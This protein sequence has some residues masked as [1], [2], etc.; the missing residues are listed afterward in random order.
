MRIA[1]RAVTALTL[2]A[3]VG[4]VPRAAGAFVIEGLDGPPTANE[5]ASLKAGLTFAP[6]PG[7]TSPTDTG[8]FNLFLG[9]HHNNYVYGESGGAIEGMIALYEITHDRDLMDSMIYFADE[10]LA[11]RN[12]R[13]QTTVGY[14]GKAELCWPNQ[15]FGAVDYGNCMTEQGDVL[16]HFTS[17]AL[18]IAR[19]PDLWNETTPVPDTLQYGATYLQRAQSYLTEA[20]KTMDGYLTPNFVNAK[21]LRFVWP[22]TD[23]YAAI[24]A[25]EAKSRGM[26]VPWNQNAMLANGYLSTALSLQVL[27]QDPAVVQQYL[28]LVE[29]WVSALLGDVVPGT[30]MGQPVYLWCYAPGQKQPCSE[31][32]GHGGYDFWG[33]YRA[34]ATPEL[35]FTLQ[36]LV[37]FANTFAYKI[38]LPAGGFAA[39]VDG[40]GTGGNVG[41]T[42]LYV[43]YFRHD[44]FKAVATPLIADATK[45]DPDTAGRILWLKYMNNGGWPAEPSVDGGAP[46]IVDAGVPVDASAPPPPSTDAGGSG[47]GGSSAGP[48]AGAGGSG[49]A[50][51]TGGATGS[52]DSGPAGASAGLT[53][54]GS[55]AS[56]GHEGCSC[57]MS[58]SSSGTPYV[59]FAMGLLAAFRYRR[60]VRR[61]SPNTR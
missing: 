53:P 42:W 21:T 2:L 11:H 45:G 5:I 58:S 3:L 34:Y 26:P 23:A 40:S 12:D 46:P 41:S 36:Q 35:G 49:A 27:G 14:T 55:G 56:S 29:T 1:R 24:G 44:L 32:T 10:I 17:I 57:R 43:P 59:S 61:S 19:S 33:V 7:P 48:D 18:E 54:G 13:W 31:D 25:S 39:R 16:G 37:P 28:A 4:L 6:F 9:N 50:V 38:I 51:G 22:D 52:T 30:A 47:S 20:R 15:D 60:R 8:P